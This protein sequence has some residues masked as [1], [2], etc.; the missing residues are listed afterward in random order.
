MA[1]EFQNGPQG[2][3]QPPTGLPAL[4]PITTDIP[5]NPVPPPSPTS[6]QLQNGPQGGDGPATGL[7]GFTGVTHVDS[8]NS[9]GSVQ[10]TGGPGTAGSVPQAGPGRPMTPNDLQE[11]F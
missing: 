8:G 4:R 7:P 11:G 2:G 3:S 6:G 1:D 9:G 10:T 5:A